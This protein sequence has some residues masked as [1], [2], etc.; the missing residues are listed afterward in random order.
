MMSITEEDFE[1]ELRSLPGVLNVGMIHRDNG[2]VEKVKLVIQG[3]NAGPIRAQATQIANLYF[4][5]VTIELEVA[6]TVQA[7]SQVAS[8]VALL[9]AEFDDAAG[10]CE[11]R[12]AFEGRVGVGRADSGR[13]IGAVEATLAALRDLRCEIPFYLEAVNTVAAVRGGP[14][15][16]AL[17]SFADDVDLF[18]IAQ[19]DGDPL[20][21]AR[22]TLNALN[23]FLTNT[24]DAN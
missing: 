8:R 12:L 20:S 6:D 17:R 24:N 5:D 9:S 23:R 4:P 19:S 16:V 22:A 15:V 11:V 3:P 13:L 7:I 21:G 18:G 1:L 14:V 10:V 2:E